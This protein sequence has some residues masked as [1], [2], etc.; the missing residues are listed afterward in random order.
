MAFLDLEKAY[1]S[2]PRELIWRTL[3]DKGTPRR[4]LRVIRDIYVGAKTRVRSTV[5]NTK[6]FAIEVGLH[7]GSAINPYLFA[8]IL[9]RTSLGAW[10][11]QTILFWYEAVHGEE[12][13]IRIGDQILQPNESFRY[14]GSVIYRSG[15]IEME[16]SIR[17]FIVLANQESSSKQGKS[18][19]LKMLRWTCGN[20][21]LDMIP[22]RVFRAELEVESI[23]HK[24]R[25]GRLRSFGHV[26]RRPQ[27]AP[28][29]RVEALLVDSLRRRGRPKL[30]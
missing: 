18:G 16:G 7:Q 14:V 2:V 4:Y 8:L 23:I 3:I 19:R 11:S 10:F 29:R 21:M 13:I 12:G 5:G 25:E 6:F 22:N 17:S 20:T 27:T 1:D 30:G 28:V 9:K 15:R 24:M 26:K